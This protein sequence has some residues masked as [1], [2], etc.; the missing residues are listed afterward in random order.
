MQFYKSKIRLWTNQ[1]SNSKDSKSNKLS[2]KKWKLRQ[3]HVNKLKLKDKGTFFQKN[4]VKYQK[5]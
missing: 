3:I 4:K 5:V 1:L 2:N